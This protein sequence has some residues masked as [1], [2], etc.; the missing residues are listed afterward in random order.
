MLYFLEKA[1]KIAAA[2]VALPSNPRCPPAARGS[3]PQVAIPNQFMCYFLALRGFLDI[4][5]IIITTYYLMSD[6]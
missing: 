5:K 3:A 1:G 2:M 6:S 4:A